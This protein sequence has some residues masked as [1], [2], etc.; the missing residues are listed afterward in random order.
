M[1]GPQGIAVTN[2]LEKLGFE[3][4]TGSMPGSGNTAKMTQHTID[5]LKGKSIHV[6]DGG[7]VEIKPGDA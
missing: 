5:K 2:A 4:K 3:V 7:D 6:G 1:A